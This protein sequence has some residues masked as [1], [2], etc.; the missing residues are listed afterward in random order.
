MFIIGFQHKEDRKDLRGSAMS[1]LLNSNYIHCELIFS[2]GY[3]G[4]SGQWLGVEVWKETEKRNVN[5]W[6]FYELPY[7]VEYNARKYVEGKKGL[8]YNWA[9]IWGQMLFPL[10]LSN[11]GFC[12]ADLCYLALIKGG[13]NL[14]K[15]DPESVSPNDLRLMIKSMNFKRIY[16]NV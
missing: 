1:V 9:G 15:F 13:L 14:P 8:P 11:V 12:C 4:S 2:D 7:E 6:E 10:G 16:Y 5:T 3:T